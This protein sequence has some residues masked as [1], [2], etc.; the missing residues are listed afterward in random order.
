MS[1][2]SYGSSKAVI[3]VTEGKV[4]GRVVSRTGSKCEPERVQ[5][6]KDFAP[7]EN[8][9]HIRQFL[10]STNWIRWFLPAWYPAVARILTDFLRPGKVFPKLGFGHKDGVSDGDKA[11]RA[12]KKMVENHIE[13]AVLDEVG[14]INGSR[15]LDMT[16]DAC[17]YGWGATS[18]QISTDFCK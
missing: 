5:A 11:V 2:F 4:L 13:N 10:G 9:N 8:P 18:L 3:G 14:A 15:P 6:I 12:I 7:L 1:G 17:G 16:S